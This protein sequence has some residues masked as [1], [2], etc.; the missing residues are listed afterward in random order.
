MMETRP[1]SATYRFN[2]R[3]S[4]NGAV[5]LSV[6]SSQKITTG[7]QRS[8][9]ELPSWRKIIRSG[10]NATTNFSAS[11]YVLTPVPVTAYCIFQGGKPTPA[12]PEVNINY[13]GDDSAVL[14][15]GTGSVNS[16]DFDRAETLARELFL[17]KY[18]QSRTAFQTGVFL[19][20]LRQ[21]VQMIKSPVR[22]LREGLNGYH[23][24]VK[25]RLRGNRR[26]SSARRIIGE[27]WLEYAFGWRPLI[28]DAA[29]AMR[30][31]CAQPAQYLVPIA[32][33][34]SSS[35][36]LEPERKFC[37]GTGANYPY[38]YQIYQQSNS[39]TVRYKGAA[40]ATM[41]APTF[42]EQLGLSWSNVLPTVWE[43]IPYS[44]LIDYFTNV[45]EIIAGIST[46]SVN[47]AWGCRTQRVLRS[48]KMQTQYDRKGLTTS[49]GHSFHSGSVNGAGDIGHRKE[50]TRTRVLS[51]SFGLSDLRFQVP[52]ATS[53]KW[54]NLAALA[55][56]R[57]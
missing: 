53:L 42:K 48:V 55:S 35:Y 13:W 32:A 1:D 23:R 4:D 26:P 46:G 20:E 11:E 51:V 57:K 49:L 5:T 25:K 6:T 56:L 50:I 30:L 18:R 8:G 52:G 12:H 45:G 28:R 34:G 47:L 21:T 14:L 16:A 2:T 37:L 9:S 15:P 39:V 38:W 31:A 54:L 33:T 44:F 43:L 29:D 22:A 7:G 3:R 36:N 27:T 19:G 41:G 40:A 10:G 24:T 17:K